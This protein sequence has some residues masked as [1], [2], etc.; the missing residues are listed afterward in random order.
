MFKEY[1]NDKNI[2][3]LDFLADHI[4]Y[5]YTTEEIQQQINFVLD[6]ELDVLLDFS[7]IDLELERYTLNIDNEMIKSMLKFDFEWGKKIADSL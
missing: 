3:I 1:L 6:K 5:G 4:R 7:L 2:E